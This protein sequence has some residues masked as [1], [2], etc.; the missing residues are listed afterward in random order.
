M[1][2][3]DICVPSRCSQKAYISAGDIGIILPHIESYDDLAVT[4]I[5][6]LIHA[7]DDWMK[8]YENRRKGLDRETLERVVDEEAFETYR[9]NPRMVQF[10]SDVYE[11]DLRRAVELVT[12]RSYVPNKSDMG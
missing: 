4:L 2:A 12:K 3:G 1:H 6:E 7:R 5:H 10:I 9:R 8:K 11:L